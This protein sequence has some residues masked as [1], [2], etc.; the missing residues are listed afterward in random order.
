MRLLRR[1]LVLATILVHFVV[2]YVLSV[3][4]V[5]GQ[6]IGPVGIVAFG[7]VLAQFT[8]LSIWAGLGT[9]RWYLRLPMA[10]L[11]ACLVYNEIM[12][13]FDRL[14]VLLIPQLFFWPAGPAILLGFVFF[15]LLLARDSGFRL[16]LFADEPA[17]HGTSFQ[18]SI[19]GM[20]VI[21]AVLAAMLAAGNDMD[22][23][24]LPD[25]PAMLWQHALGNIP[26]WDK[27][28][29]LV[30][31]TSLSLFVGGSLL[32]VWACLSLGSVGI[33]LVV[34]GATCL[35]LG[36]LLAYYLHGSLWTYLGG[37][38]LGALLFGVTSSTLL[39][40]RWYGYRFSRITI[41]DT[42]HDSLGEAS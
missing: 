35:S 26:I 24:L 42:S 38:F 13:F 22:G 40:F 21:T 8:L 23:H 6:A 9:A 27:Q 19:R 10:Y 20:L 15:P 14:T 4:M 3:V 34:G 32:S 37:C 30:V 12:F 36:A 7:V 1:Y 5:S 18:M 28:G 11:G 29:V 41:V 2:C 33:R 16:L 31:A 39:A 17:P 25:T